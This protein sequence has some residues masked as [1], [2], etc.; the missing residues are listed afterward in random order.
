MITNH[1]HANASGWVGR[2][3]LNVTVDQRG[4]ATD[5]DGYLGGSSVHLHEEDRYISGG[6]SGFEGYRNVSLSVQRDSDGSCTLS[7]QLGDD[8]YSLT[9]R[10]QSDGHHSISG[11]C[12]RTSISLNRDDSSDSHSSIS[13][14]LF[15]SGVPAE[16]VNV[17]VSGQ[18]AKGMAMEALYPVLSVLSNDR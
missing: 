16:F 17:T 10:V 8:N 11:W 7:G 2:Q 15:G 13:G 6:I 12:G 18:P 9:D 14:N 5:V 1:V 3:D 4:K